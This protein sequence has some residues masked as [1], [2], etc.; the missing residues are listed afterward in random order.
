MKDMVFADEP[1]D[2]AD[3]CSLESRAL[4]GEMR[5][6]HAALVRGAL[7]DPGDDLDFKLGLALN[8]NARFA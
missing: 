2:S 7:V 5:Q 1:F 3:D 4:L 8:A 6:R